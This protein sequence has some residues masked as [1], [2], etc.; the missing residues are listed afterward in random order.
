M[1]VEVGSLAEWAAALVTAGGLFYAGRAVT[2]QTRELK[3]AAA[4]ELRTAWDEEMRHL[5]EAAEMRW[6]LEASRNDPEQFAEVRSRYDKV[7]T[8]AVVASQ[9]FQVL[10]SDMELRRAS[11][12]P[13]DM[14]KQIPQAYLDGSKDRAQ[15]LAECYLME[16]GATSTRVLIESGRVPRRNWRQRVLRRKR[17]KARTL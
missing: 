17:G 9:R 4:G 7:I 13:I 3:D 10:T 5:A 12:T 11:L 6:E 15:F 8:A 2:L 16:V 1:S 14:L